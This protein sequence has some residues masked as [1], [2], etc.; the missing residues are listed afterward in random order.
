MFLGVASLW[1]HPESKYWFACITLPDGRRTK[2]STKTTDRKL[3]EA[4]AHRFEEATRRKATEGQARRVLGDIYQMIHG[5]RLGSATIAE[6]FERWQERKKIEVK[7]RTFER[8][9][10]IARKFVAFLGTRAEEDLSLLSSAHVTAY[11]DAAAKRLSPATAN[12]ELKVIR[13]ALQQALRDGLIESNPANRVTAI[14]RR[15]DNKA[16]RRGFTLPEL[17]SI[18]AHC[19]GEWRGLVLFGLYTGQRLSD[20]ARL[21]WQ[22]VDIERSEIRF[23]TGKTGRRQIIPLA[24]PLARYL[25]D[26]LPAGEPKAPLFPR[27]AAFVARSP[28]GKVSTLSEQFRSILVVAGMVSARERGQNVGGGH[29]NKRQLSEISFHSLRHSA[30]SLMKNAGISSAIVQDV[31]GHDSPAVSA[32]YTHIE[33]EA[34][35]QAVNSIPDLNT[36]L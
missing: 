16:E 20:L 29:S 2:R 26:S 3:A 22:N 13:V 4:I 31:I 11:R 8:Y 6:Y 18:L 19:D 17:K 12:G 36:L 35:R 24:A 21:T 27:S 32:H 9:A 28:T 15:E 1:K 33:D 30:T 14:N 34:K 23:V 25:T 7:P 10:I 5:E